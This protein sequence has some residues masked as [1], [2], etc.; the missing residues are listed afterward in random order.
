MDTESKLTSSTPESSEEYG[1][2]V[3]I[4]GDYAIVG[5][6]HGG[7][8]S[9]SAY[10]Y[11]TTGSGW[12]HQAKL[13]ASDKQG[14]DHFGQA[15]SIDG[16]YAIVGAPDG[17][18]THQGHAY[19]FHRSGSSWT[20]QA[21][22]TAA[23]ATDYGSFGGSVSISGDYV[24]I[25]AAK[26]AYIFHRTGS[27][28]TQQA[29]LTSPSPNNA[30]SFGR[31]VSLSG[32]HAIVGDPFA[33][34]GGPN[35][36]A[37]YIFR[38]SGTAWNL[39][40][41]AL[42]ASDRVVYDDFGWS[43]AISGDHAI[44]GAPGATADGVEEAGGAYMFLRWGSNWV[45]QAKLEPSDPHPSKDFGR[46]VA[47][48]GNHALVG[49]PG[50]YDTAPGSGAAYLYKR[51]SSGWVMSGPKLTASDA[52]EF[53]NF[54][55]SVGISTAHAIVGAPDATDTFSHQGVAYVYP[56]PFGLEAIT[57]KYSIFA[58][59]LFGL[60]GGGGGVIILPGSGPRPVDPEPFR[61]WNNLPSA[62]RDLL[63]GLALTEIASLIHDKES[64]QQTKKTGE[65][66]TTK[67]ATNLSQPRTPESKRQE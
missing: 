50:D 6:R 41:P 7:F 49:D 46:S 63:V 12:T 56:L 47:I 64:K 8:D 35:Q 13:N 10:I 58:Q 31:S 34:G 28:W 5:A 11:L 14:F 45:P 43:V 20:E 54:G 67:A 62:K 44:V 9:G 3:A 38:R 37:A 29:E 24:I 25:G 66:L 61:V 26:T 22:L 2:S 65:D 15:V 59:I 39:Q 30:S 4:S 52:A 55:Q 32:D 57:D 18:D 27:S 16:D 17:G 36:G 19:I 53:S 33:S 48:S 21:E 40:L 42:T 60:I 23:D 51:T 1:S